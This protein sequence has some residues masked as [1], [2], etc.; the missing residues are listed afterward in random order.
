MKV[1]FLDRD[2]VI[3]KEVNYLY[4]KEK[5]EFTF[6]CVDALRILNSIGYKI[7]IV[8][9]QAGIAKGY[10]SEQEYRDFTSWYLDLL[11]ANNIEI[12]DIFYCPHHPDGNI[13]AYSKVCLCRKPK[14]GLILSA[15]KKYDID[16]SKSILVGDK[17]SDI[18][19]G[20]AVGIEDLFLVR[21]GH[22]LPK[23]T[24]FKIG[25]SNNLFEV[26][27][28]LIETQSS[29]FRKSIFNF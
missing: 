12:L 13:A 29:N 21:S 3:N 19:A 8:T 24:E 17:I 23:Y 11:K 5:F 22:P 4:E 6:R 10:Y 9:N 14:P 28:S 25:V 26:A 1:A 20:L 15:L 16:L 2:G 27:K 7:I 18:K